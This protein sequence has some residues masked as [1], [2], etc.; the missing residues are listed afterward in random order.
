MVTNVSE[1]RLIMLFVEALD[2]PLRG[3][4]KAYKPT[5]LQDAIER[6]RDL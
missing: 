5:T 6:T 3:S 1:S 4:V 2:E